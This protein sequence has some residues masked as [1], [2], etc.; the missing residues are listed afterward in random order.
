MIMI[1]HQP[2][3]VWGKTSGVPKAIIPLYQVNPNGV[4]SVYCLWKSGRHDRVTHTTET[5]T[6]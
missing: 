5:A 1:K 6:Q 3:A 4:S 2:N